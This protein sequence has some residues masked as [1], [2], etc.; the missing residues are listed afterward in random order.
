MPGAT[1]S[2]TVEW[3]SAHVMPSRVMW[4]SAST[5][6]CTPTTAFNLSSATVVAGLVRSTW[7][8][9]A[10]RQ[11]VGIDLQPDGESGQWVDMLL[12]NLVQSQRVG[13]QLFV[14]ERIEAEYAPAFGDQ[15]GG[16]RLAG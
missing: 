16:H 2:S 14:A 7:P 13:P 8:E 10:R 1:E 3:Q 4:L 15:C 6:A 12:D 9:D 5:V 11:R